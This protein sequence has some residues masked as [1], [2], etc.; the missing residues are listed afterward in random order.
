MKIK[1]YDENDNIVKEFPFQQLNTSKEY[2]NI[3]YP[4]FGKNTLKEDIEM[5]CASFYHLLTDRGLENVII[6]PS[7]E[8][9]QIPY[10]QQIK[11][12]KE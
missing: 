12:E 7:D 9:M 11:I 1:V 2:V 10:I 8:D 6:L 5:I 3:V 4:K